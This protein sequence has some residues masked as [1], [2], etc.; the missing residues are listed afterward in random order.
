MPCFLI[1]LRFFKLHISCHGSH[2]FIRYIFTTHICTNTFDGIK[3]SKRYPPPAEQQGDH[4]IRNTTYGPVLRLLHQIHTRGTFECDYD[5]R[6]RICKVNKLGSI[7]YL[8]LQVVGS[9]PIDVHDLHKQSIHHCLQQ[10][11]LAAANG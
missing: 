7:V 6:N 2:H 8:P 11:N 9:K 1:L 3:W 4:C 5:Q 10:F